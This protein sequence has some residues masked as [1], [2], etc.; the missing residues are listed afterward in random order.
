MRVTA[1]S[2]RVQVFTGASNIGCVRLAGDR[3]AFIDSG[4]DSKGAENLLRWL[5]DCKLRLVAILNTHAHA[6]HIGGNRTLQE[7]TKCRVFAGPLEAPAV[8]HPLIQAIALFGGLPIPELINPRIVAEASSDVETL[9]AET[10]SLDDVEFKV[11]DLSGHS[12]GQKGFIVDGVAFYADSL[13]SSE[14]VRRDRLIYLY[15]PL[16]Y[17]EACRHLKDISAN[18]FVGGHTPPM[19]NIQTLIAENVGQVEAVLAFLRKLLATPQPLD[20]LLK[21]FLGH[22]SVRKGGWSHFLYR[23]TLNGYLSALQRL[24]E[25]E[26]KVLDNLLVWYASEKPR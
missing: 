8:S 25:A 15:D 21:N 24:R 18:S 14:V 16:S 23:A 7:A 1:V 20:R 5:N 10:L 4:V 3:V 22:F 12:V 11:M 2:N 6:D 13:F 19:A 17:I 9:P 26:F